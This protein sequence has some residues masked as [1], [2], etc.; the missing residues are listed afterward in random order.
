MKRP[1]GLTAI[2]AIA[3]VSSALLMFPAVLLALIA[4]AGG[5]RGAP[6]TAEKIWGG[7][8]YAALVMVLPA[9][10]I[11]T[12]IA[13]LRMRLWALASTQAFACCL[14]AAGGGMDI[15]A[16]VTVIASPTASANVIHFAVLYVV[17][18]IGLAGLGAWWLA[19]CSRLAV[20]SCCM[21]H[22][23]WARRPFGISLVGWATTIAGACCL[24]TALVPDPSVTV[25]AFAWRAEGFMAHAV[26]G[27]A[28]LAG[29][30]A[31]T[32]LLRL[33]PWARA[34]GA[35]VL[36]LAVL[37]A[38]SRTF[39]HEAAITMAY[40]AY[41]H[42]LSTRYNFDELFSELQWHTTLL[43][44]WGAIAVGG[45]FGLHLL[46]HLHAGSARPS[47]TVDVA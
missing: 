31:G 7:V 13:L 37:Y 21:A 25:T 19:Y 36:G 40:A 15:A 8:A 45:L 17:I 22:G 18:G 47:A 29:L 35:A 12:G 33:R 30:G 28:A 5:E 34:A 32:G 46:R 3:F 14:L 6:V 43:L 16:V 44:A 11:L 20:R 9:W 1:G 10:G 2:A 27:V 42:P 4:L 41:A 39:A 38:I 26:C 23:G 24:L